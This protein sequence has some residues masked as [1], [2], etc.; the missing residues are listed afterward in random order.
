MNEKIKA[1]KAPENQL[2][3]SSDNLDKPITKKKLT[4]SERVALK[5]EK[6]QQ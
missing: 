6:Q 2:F 1:D 5:I 3:A 4:L